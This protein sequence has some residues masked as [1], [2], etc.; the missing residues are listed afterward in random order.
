MA[1]GPGQALAKQN[2]GKKGVV[3]G[4]ENL[5]DTCTHLLSSWAMLLL[6]VLAQQE[7]IRIM[8]M[9]RRPCLHSA[10]QLQSSNVEYYIL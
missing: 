1:L 3:G 6:G 5:S 8:R 2:H 7:D 9:E 4:K 10:A